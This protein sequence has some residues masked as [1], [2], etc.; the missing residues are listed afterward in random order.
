ML[1]LLVELSWKTGKMFSGELLFIIKWEICVY[2]TYSPNATLTP[3]VH[4]AAQS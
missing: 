3:V 4:K 2:F 1:Y